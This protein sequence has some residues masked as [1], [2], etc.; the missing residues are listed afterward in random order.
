MD[1]ILE[2]RSYQLVL[3]NGTSSGQCPWN[4]IELHEKIVHCIV[5]LTMLIAL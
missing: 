2:T 4:T 5:M 1:Y 3:A